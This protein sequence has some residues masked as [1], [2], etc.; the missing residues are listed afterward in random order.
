[1]WIFPEKGDPD[2][3]LHFGALWS[4]YGQ[5]QLHSLR[6]DAVGVRLGA[7][8]ILSPIPSLVLTASKKQRQKG[9]DTVK[10]IK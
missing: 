7:E 10:L 5:Q 6:R 1:M 3:P 8:H 4:P 2:Q 9:Y